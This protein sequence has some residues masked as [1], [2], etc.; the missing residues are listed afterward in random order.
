MELIKHSLN[1]ADDKLIIE[2]LSQY[3]EEETAPVKSKK[4][5]KAKMKPKKAVKEIKTSREDT[6]DKP[7]KIMS[8]SSLSNDNSTSKKKG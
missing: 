6:L 4:S 2:L 5:P 7:R 1:Q 8:K 3:E